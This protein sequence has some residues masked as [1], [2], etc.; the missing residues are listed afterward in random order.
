MR[1]LYAYFIGRK[2]S[3]VRLEYLFKIILRLCGRVE[4]S[5]DLFDF[6]VDV[7]NCCIKLFFYVIF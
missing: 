6:K 2:L 5:L 7:F 1:K 3:L 4:L